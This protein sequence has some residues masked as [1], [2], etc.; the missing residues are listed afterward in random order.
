MSS[1]L[2]SCIATVLVG[3]ALIGCWLGYNLAFPKVP[4]LTS[5]SPDG[6]LQALLI[7]Q[8]DRPMFPLVD[9]CVNLTVLRNSVTLLSEIEVHCG[10]QLDASFSEL[11]PRQRWLD[12]T[13]LQFYNDNYHGDRPNDLLTVTNHS[14][15]KLKYLKLTSI[16]VIIVLD[17]APGINLK[18]QVAGAR[19]DWQWLSAEGELADGTVLARQHRS[20]ENHQPSIYD[21][22]VEENGI[23][24][25]R[26]KKL[27]PKD[28]K[29]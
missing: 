4:F 1:K 28:P 8:K 11:F 27:P 13:A 16:D 21:V 10:D 22:T 9:H 19:S 7:G 2:L 20:F 3:M 25:S 15:K 18:F 17:A 24:L 5:S 26:I 29:L 23:T 12:N 14:S 6:T